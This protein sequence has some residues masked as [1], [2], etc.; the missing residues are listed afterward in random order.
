MAEGKGDVAKLNKALRAEHFAIYGYGVV[1]G[2]SEGGA[3]A[4]ATAL[5][6]AHRTRRD[7]LVELIGAEGGQPAASEAAYAMPAVKSPTALAAQ[8]EGTVLDA[9]LA[10][11]GAS[12]GQLRKFAAQAMQEAMG[13]QVRWSR[14]G[15]AESFPGLAPSD[16]VPTASP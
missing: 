16:V 12:T 3:R 13:R 11:A 2:R 14:T 15:P 10:L 8:L 6:E 5:W 9:Y 1:G 4:L 7:R